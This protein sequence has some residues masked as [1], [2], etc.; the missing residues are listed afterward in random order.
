MGR[1]IDAKP[2]GWDKVVT[3]LVGELE[4]IQKTF[5]AHSKTARE[6]HEALN[7]IMGQMPQGNQ[8]QLVRD[9]KTE[10]DKLEAQKTEVQR[11]YEAA[12][13]KVKNAKVKGLTFPPLVLK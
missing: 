9:A 10:V 3:G 11:P 1:A 12:S 8:H 6:L 13:Q 7:K 4:T 5:R 2:T